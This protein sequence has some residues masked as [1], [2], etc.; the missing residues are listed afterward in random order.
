LP[1]RERREEKNGEMIETETEIEKGGR[2]GRERERE[3]ERKMERDREKREDAK[4]R[5]MISCLVACR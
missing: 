5:P 3:R 1:V 4:L 2:G